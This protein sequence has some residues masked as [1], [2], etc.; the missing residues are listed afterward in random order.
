MTASKSGSVLV[1][2]DEVELMQA[3]CDGLGANN[4]LVKGVTDPAAAVEVLRRGDYD[5]LLSDLMMPVMDGI[6]LLKH[7]LEADPNLVGI[8]MTGQGT[9]QTA[10]EAMKLGAFDYILKPFKLQFILPILARAMEV[11]RLRME[12]VRLKAHL[13]RLIFES[14]RMQLIGSGPAMQKVRQMIEK[15]AA[16]DSTVLVR[17][18]SGSGK[19]LVARA[20]HHNSRRRD[21]PLVVINCAA[22]QETLLESELFGYEKGAFTGATQSKRG[23]FEVAEDGTLFIDEIAEMSAGMQAKLLRVLED[24]SYRRV[25]GTQEY[26]A[27]VRVIAATN[28]PLEQEQKAGRFREDLFY[29]LNVINIV[30][31]PLKERKEDIPALIEHFLTTRQ[32]GKTRCKVDPEAMEALTAY[33]WPGNVRELANVIE[34]AQILAEEDTITVDDLPENMVTAA[35]DV[36]ASAEPSSNPSNLRGVER[37]HVQE[38]LRQAKGNKVHAA[39]A[40]GVSRRALYRLIAKYKLE[41]LPAERPEPGDSTEEQ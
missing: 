19:E 20:L 15:V 37:R 25:G 3:L 35:P 2:D 29:R 8:I 14:S 30:L 17:G 7:G 1:V 4:Y 22:L 32:I 5:V 31:P 11:R 34:R 28:K 16:T 36:P 18:P 38:V 21:M 39:K 40:L 12:N 10:V 9:V 23:L 27:N 6:Q 41:P 13:D 33:D 26:H 24:G